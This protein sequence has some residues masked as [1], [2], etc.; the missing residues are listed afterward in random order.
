MASATKPAKRNSWANA[1]SISPDIAESVYVDTGFP[2]PAGV[3]V[4]PTRGEFNFEFHRHDEGMNSIFQRG[5]LAWD[6]NETDYVAGSAVV[7]GSDG[8]VYVLFGTATPATSPQTDRGNWMPVLNPLHTPI[9]LWDTN[10]TQYMV[11]DIVRGSDGAIYQAVDNPTLGATPVGNMVW[12]CI[13]DRLGIRGAKGRLI[14]IEEDWCSVDASQKI[15]LASGAWFGRWNFGN[16]GVG[17]AW[18][19]NANGPVANSNF[20]RGSLVSLSNNGTTANAACVVEAATSPFRFMT[21]VATYEVDASVTG[22]AD[23]QTNSSFAFGLGPGT[24]VS[25]ALA[26]RFTADFEVLGVGFM[27][28]AS[29]VNWELW[30]KKPGGSLGITNTGVTFVRNVAH[31]FRIEIIGSNHSTGPR[32]VAF[33]D[34][35]QVANLSG[36]TYDM[37]GGG[38]M[39]AFPFFRSSGVSGEVTTLNAGPLVINARRF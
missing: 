31:R 38:G 13:E 39:A 18:A 34:D 25:G 27:K 35:A 36:S 23:P 32:I 16:F 3:P 9:P 10:E 21:S 28:A 2:A 5:I 15:A 20:P 1:V 19:I 12:M 6:T 14:E 29:G 7:R 37:A 33:I 8:K 30:T 4:V 17:G 11:G 26:S 22:A 24:L